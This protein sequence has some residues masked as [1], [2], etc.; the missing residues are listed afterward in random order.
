MGGTV[1][2]PCAIKLNRQTWLAGEPS[3]PDRYVASNNAGG[4]L[5]LSVSL[6]YNRFLRQKKT[7]RRRPKS[8]EE[9]PKEGIRRQVVAPL[10]YAAPHQMQWAKAPNGG[11]SAPSQLD[12]AAA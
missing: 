9:T 1:S 3:Q 8:R 11:K 7:A 10:P 12:S 2:D 4:C 5:L 6:G